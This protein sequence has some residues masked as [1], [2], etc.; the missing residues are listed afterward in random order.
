MI[1]FMELLSPL[2]WGF[3]SFIVGARGEKAFCTPEHT[4]KFAKITIEKFVVGSTVQ[5]ECLP[6]YKRSP[7]STG[8][9][10]CK[11]ISGQIQW[12]HRKRAFQCI[13]NKTISEVKQNAE[14]KDS[15]NFTDYCGNSITHARA[16]VTTGKYALG[17]ELLFVCKYGCESSHRCSGTIGC[18]HEKGT[19]VWGKPSR[20]C[21]EPGPEEPNPSPETPSSDHVVTLIAAGPEE[22]IPSPETPSSDLVVTFVVAASSIAVLI[23]G[24]LLTRILCRKQR[25][26]KKPSRE[27]RSTE[28][29]K[30]VSLA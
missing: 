6:G 25:R 27:N 12:T 17:Q 24:I 1:K 21:L 30:V 9:L 18:I 10:T 29:E 23:I 16:N 2:I 15:N 20:E 19:T 28:T 3:S 14:A 13:D 11:N 7:G 5:F 8:Y 22:P 26:K 4:A